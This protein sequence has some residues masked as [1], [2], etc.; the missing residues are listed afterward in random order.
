MGN[1]PS[2]QPM[3]YFEMRIDG[4]PVDPLTQLP[5]R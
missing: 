5:R 3:L 2:Q 1:G 4:E